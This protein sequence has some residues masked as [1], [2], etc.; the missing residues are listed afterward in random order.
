MDNIEALLREKG[1]TKTAFSEMLGIRKQNLNAL[2]KNP[3]LETMKRFAAALDVPM[4]QLFVS[5][6]EVHQQ[7]PKANEEAVITCP[8]CGERIAVHLQTGL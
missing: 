8:Y 1:L 5:P 4:W 2:L 7:P 3:T 6:E